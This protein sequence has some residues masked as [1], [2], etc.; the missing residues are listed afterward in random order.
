M[1]E[2][3][4]E[5]SA[6]LGPTLGHGDIDADVLR[7]N[8]AAYLHEN[9]VAKYLNLL[10]TSFAAVTAYEDRVARNVLG[11]RDDVDA[12]RTGCVGFS[13]G[14]MRASMLGATAEGIAARVIVGMMATYEELLDRLVAPHTWML[15]PAGLGRVGDVPDLAGSAAPAPLLVQ[16]A[17]GD[18][19]FTEKGMRD[20]D[21][22][23]RGYYERAGAPGA[24]RG[25]FYAGPHRFDL[26]MQER[27]FEWFSRELV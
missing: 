17:L 25:E 10:G 11:G 9:I 26:E 7:Y 21:R 15:F 20:A 19:M 18:A 12:R 1:P 14:G 8:G 27:A 24:Y 13:G 6:A 5:F 22:R 2:R 3:D 16:Y 23:I 4:T